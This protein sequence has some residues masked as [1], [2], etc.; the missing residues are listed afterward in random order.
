MLKRPQDTKPTAGQRETFS[1]NI[2]SEAPTDYYLHQESIPLP[3]GAKGEQQEIETWKALITN[4]GFREDIKRV[5]HRLGPSYWQTLSKIQ[6]I[7]EQLENQL[8]EACTHVLKAFKKNHPNLPISILP[9]K[10]KLLHETELERLSV[11]WGLNDLKDGDEWLEHV[12]RFWDPTSNDPPP[13]EAPMR[14]VPSEILDL[15]TGSTYTPPRRPLFKTIIASIEYSS[16]TSKDSSKAK[17]RRAMITLRPGVSIRQ[18]QRAATEAVKR[19]ESKARRYRP[20]LTDL[21]RSVLRVLFEIHKPSLGK[22]T[23]SWVIRTVHQRLCDGQRPISVQKIGKEL[24]H[25]LKEKGY[26]VKS[27]QIDQSDR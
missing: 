24:R 21:D 23:R 12:L 8:N 26:R 20:A 2:Q 14:T 10:A 19:L 1:P 27:Y 18:A 13:L 4:A 22:Q 7:S 16:P 9:V 11:K 25:W 3:F 6:T 5:Q 15:P 17:P